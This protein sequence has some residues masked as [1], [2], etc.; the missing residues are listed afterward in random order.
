MIFDVL[1]HAKA[2]QRCMGGALV[3][4]GNGGRQVFWAESWQP[5]HGSTADLMA[6]ALSRDWHWCCRQIGT[7]AVD[8]LRAQHAQQV[9]IE[10][11]RPERSCAQHARR[12]HNECRQELAQDW[13]RKAVTLV[14]SVCAGCAT[15]ASRSWAV[16]GKWLKT[17]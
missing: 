14:P 15:Q 3:K 17:C 1:H 7:E 16:R 13:K 11:A 10:S 6:L 9:S 2:S 4:Q 12:M 5:R 8:R